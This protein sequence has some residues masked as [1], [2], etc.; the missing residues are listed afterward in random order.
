MSEIEDRIAAHR[1]TMRKRFD[2][3][4]GVRD[5]GQIHLGPLNVDAM[6]DSELSVVVEHP[7]LHNT[8]KAYASCLRE[9][10]KLRLEGNIAVAFRLERKLETMYDHHIPKR[11]LW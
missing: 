5:D 6:D 4:F 3:D 7:A 2:A 11:L 9:A 10:R 8:V 1:E